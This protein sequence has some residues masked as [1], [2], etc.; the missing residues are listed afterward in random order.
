MATLVTPEPTRLRAIDSINIASMYSGTVGADV[1]VVHMTPLN[2]P[3]TVTVVCPAATTA[4]VEFS[5]TPNA[6]KNYATANWQFWPYGTVGA[7]TSVTQTFTGRLSALRF[8]RA[9]GTGLVTY[10]VTA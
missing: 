10:E 9:S 4:T 6:Y 8:T 5:T 1:Q 2:S 3:A 7:A